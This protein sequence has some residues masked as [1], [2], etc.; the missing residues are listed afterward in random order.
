MERLK[1]DIQRFAGGGDPY[2]GYFTVRGNYYSDVWNYDDT[3]GR[4][5]LGHIPTIDDEDLEYYGYT[6]YTNPHF[7]SWTINGTN[8]TV[9][10]MQNLTPT[11]SQVESMTD[12][13]AW[14]EEAAA[15]ITSNAKISFGNN[16]IDSVCLGWSEVDAVVF[17]NELLWSKGKILFRIRDNSASAGIYY[18]LADEGTT[19]SDWLNSSYNTKGFYAGNIGQYSGVITNY[20]GGD[21]YIISVNT[22]DVITSQMYYSTFRQGSEK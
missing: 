22:N 8:Y 7:K 6:G 15:P 16:E 13:W 1:L 21:G 11:Y 18:F 19:W 5:R 20:L 4:Y 2:L 17:N 3:I 9:Y 14:V 12:A 10:E